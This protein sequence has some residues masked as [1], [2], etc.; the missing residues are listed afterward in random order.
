[1]LVILTLARKMIISLKK[2]NFVTKLK[3]VGGERTK[4]PFLEP[5][6]VGLTLQKIA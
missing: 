6:K 2:T 5:R 3:W 4:H 1:V